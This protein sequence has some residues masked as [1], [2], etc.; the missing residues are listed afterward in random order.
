MVEY[1]ILVNFS[2]T[3]AQPK[4][5]AKKLA[6]EYARYFLSHLELERFI[7]EDSRLAATVLADEQGEISEIDIAQFGKTM[8]G[9]DKV[10]QRIA[11]EDF[12]TTPDQTDNE[13]RFHRTIGPRRVLFRLFPIYLGDR[14]KLDEAPTFTADRHNAKQTVLS[15]TKQNPRAQAEKETTPQTIAQPNKDITPEETLENILSGIKT[16]TGARATYHFELQGSMITSDIYPPK[17]SVITEYAMPDEAEQDIRQVKGVVAYSSANSRVRIHRRNPAEKFD[18][19]GRMCKDSGMKFIAKNFDEQETAAVYD[20]L[21]RLPFRI[22]TSD[23]SEATV[24]YDRNTIFI[25]PKGDA[26]IDIV[27]YEEALAAKKATPKARDSRTTRN[28]GLPDTEYE[29]VVFTSQ[30]TLRSMLEETGGSGKK[31]VFDNFYE[32]HLT[33]KKDGQ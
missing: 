8:Q 4:R 3:A 27:G 1:K 29:F 26:R 12:C 32:Q 16:S 30:S 25:C 17:G 33:E 23:T 14:Q 15:P 22:K 13:Y 18:V 10:L 20:A 24:V 31:D 11:E 19:R 9:I 6:E 28:F 2:E 21:S 5:L 7:P